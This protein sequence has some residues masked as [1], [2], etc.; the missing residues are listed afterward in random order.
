MSRWT[1]QDNE[2]GIVTTD[3]LFLDD[4]G[5]EVDE[6]G[7]LLA[8]QSYHA[9]QL[10]RQLDT[11]ITNKTQAMQALMSSQ[12]LERD[13]VHVFLCLFTVSSKGAII[14]LKTQTV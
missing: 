11:K 3:E 13:K 12:K 2:L 10:L 8:D 6:E 14:G 1:N 5:E 4:K 7:E 9:R